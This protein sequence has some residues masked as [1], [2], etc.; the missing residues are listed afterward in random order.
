MY[1]L[2]VGSSPNHISA[3]ALAKACA[4]WSNKHCSISRVARILLSFFAIISHFTCYLPHRLHTILAKVRWNPTVQI[5]AKLVCTES[6][7]KFSPVLTNSH[8][9]TVARSNVGNNPQKVTALPDTNTL[10]LLPY[11]IYIFKRDVT[12]RRE[13]SISLWT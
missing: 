1:L 3:E 5:K 13:S 12:N 6:S 10:Y 9:S 7:H 8:H 2:G 11:Y 4:V